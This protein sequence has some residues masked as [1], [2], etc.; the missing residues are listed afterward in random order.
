MCSQEEHSRRETQNSKKTGGRKNNK[1]QWARAALGG[2]I[3]GKTPGKKKK[4]AGGSKG[5]KEKDTRN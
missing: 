2:K 4:E 5:E 1:R 3:K